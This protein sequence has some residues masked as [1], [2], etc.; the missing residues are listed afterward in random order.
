MGKS[1]Q[2]KK[3]SLTLNSGLRENDSLETPRPRGQR[4][5]A[6]SQPREPKS[7]A[8]DFDSKPSCHLD[9]GYE[10]DDSDPTID[11]MRKVHRHNS[12]RRRHSSSDDHFHTKKHNNKHG[13]TSND[14]NGSQPPSDKLQ[15]SD[16]DSTIDLPDR[17][18]SQGRLVPQEENTKPMR[19][20]LE[21]LMNEINRVFS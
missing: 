13:N 3:T 6:V 21:D 1:P 18:D 10:T 4:P 9:P 14:N 20:P 5:R 16:S 17:F 11:S 2:Y 15:R 12:H 7:V 19:D 8:F